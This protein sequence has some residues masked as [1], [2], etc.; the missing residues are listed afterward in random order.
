MTRLSI[1][2]RKLHNL[3]PHLVRDAV[4]DGRWPGWLIFQR[5]KPASLVE[6]APSAKRRSRHAELF[7]RL[8]HRQMRLFDEAKD[9][10]LLGDGISHSS[11]PHPR[12]CFF[13]QPQFERLFGDAGAGP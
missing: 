3:V 7:Q 10:Q 9:F 4:P 13:K 2:K 6:V 12:S 8:F 5:L 11:S 1:H